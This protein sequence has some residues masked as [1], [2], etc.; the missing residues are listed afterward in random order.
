MDWNDRKIRDDE[1]EINKGK[2]AYIIIIN[3]SY[4]LR[5]ECAFLKENCN[6]RRLDVADKPYSRLKRM[7]RVIMVAQASFFYSVVINRLWLSNKHFRTSRKMG[8]WALDWFVSNKKRFDCL[9]I[10][11]IMEKMCGS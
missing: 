10:Y 3:F 5:R 8:E 1:H 9:G 7:I 11:A 4:V 2:H 6:R